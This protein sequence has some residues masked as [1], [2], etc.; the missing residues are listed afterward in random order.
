MH[1]RLFLV[2]LMSLVNIRDQEK[3]HWKMSFEEEFEALLN[4]N[5]LRQLRWLVDGSHQ[6]TQP[7][8]AKTLSEEKQELLTCDTENIARPRPQPKRS[9][10]NRQ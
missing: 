6:S 8:S 5:G 1:K 10:P 9:S 7:C 4:G 3:H 2:L